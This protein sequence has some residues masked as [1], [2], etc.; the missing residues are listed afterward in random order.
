MKTAW[1]IHADLPRIATRRSQRRS[2]AVGNGER[3]SSTLTAILSPLQCNGH[4]PTF[5]PT[6]RSTAA[7]RPSATATRRGQYAELPTD[8]LRQSFPTPS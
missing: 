7:S 1:H 5:T 6:P 4:S 8:V 2:D 3:L